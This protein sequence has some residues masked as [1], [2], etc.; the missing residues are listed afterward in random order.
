ME[1]D[2]N[3]KNIMISAWF[4]HS[5]GERYILSFCIQ[6]LDLNA[7]LVTT[8]L[9]QNKQGTVN[10]KSK[11]TKHNDLALHE[12]YKTRVVGNCDW[13][14]C[15]MHFEMDGW[16][17]KNMEKTHGMRILYLFSYNRILWCT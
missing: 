5:T 1:I 7:N 4:L 13:F 3:D 2:T 17:N 8:G 11:T 16:Q 12:S 9:G 15:D 14:A 6:K 10:K